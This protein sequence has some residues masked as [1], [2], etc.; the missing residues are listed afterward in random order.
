[1]TYRYELHAPT[2]LD[3]MHYTSLKTSSNNLDNVK[4]V[5]TELLNSYPE[6]LNNTFIRDS[7]TG[8]LIMAKPIYNFF[9]VNP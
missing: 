7:Q 5:M 6:F 3:D 4:M 8:I 1:M 9:E 2:N